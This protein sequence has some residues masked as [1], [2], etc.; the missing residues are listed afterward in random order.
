VFVN[1]AQV[2]VT[3]LLLSNLAAGSRVVR[4]ELAGYERWSS[5]VRIITSEETKVDAQ[6]RPS[7]I[8]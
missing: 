6:L 8:R 1:G 5:A 2:G 7:P 3:P 4:L